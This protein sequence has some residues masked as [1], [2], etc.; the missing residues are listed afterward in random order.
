MIPKLSKTYYIN[1]SSDGQKIGAGQ[2]GPSDEDGIPM[3]N[4]NERY[5]TAGL[6]HENNVPFGVHY[7]PVTISIYAFSLLQGIVDGN[8]ATDSHQDRFFQLVD[9]LVRTIVPISPEAGVW[10]HSFQIPFS[11]GLSP[12]YASGIAQAQAISLLLRAYQL[13]ADDRYLAVAHQAFGAFLVDID[14]GGVRCIEGGL[15]WIEEWPSKPRS[16]V[17]NG[18][19][20]ALLAIYDYKK[21]FGTDAGTELWVE[22]LRTLTHNIEFFDSSYGS[23]Y[24]LLRGL[25]VSETYHQLHIKLLR[26]LYQLSGE[27]A[28]LEV[29][30]RWDSYLL[31]DSSFKRRSLAFC[32]NML[33]NPEY[34]ACKFR[35]IIRRFG[36]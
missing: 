36:C 4:Y 5:R 27:D 15:T 8:A 35:Q 32:E 33:H 20:F 29:A 30:E 23:R 1:F 34:R 16:H 13:R 3:V 12:P 24:D 10:Q 9:W 6:R 25:V 21:F 11:A 19:M 17:L 18:F 2:L 26:E 14:D 31:R 28:L 22:G 7:T